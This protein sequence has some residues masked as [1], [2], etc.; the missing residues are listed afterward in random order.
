MALAIAFVAASWLTVLVLG[1]DWMPHFR[2]LLPTFPIV[3]LLAARGVASSRRP[4]AAIV[5]GALLLLTIL[6]GTIG[7][8]MFLAE[9]VTVT[10]FARLGSR[11]ATVLPPGTTIGCGSPGAIGFHSDLPVLDI[12]G[13]TDRWIARHGAVVGTQ[14]G[15][16]KTDGAYVVERKPDLLLL[17][18]IQIHRGRRER[19][20][21]PVK[22]QER[23]IIR[24]P[25]FEELYEFVNVPLGGAF[26]LSC[27]K[28]KEYFLPL[29]TRTE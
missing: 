10:A 22:I 21:L 29:E 23:E 18:N 13:L 28:L 12:L 26:Y 6:P 1:G 16:F 4:R 3:A 17:G 7:Y 24:Q 27:F 14:P 2:L 8:D 5:A 19:E 11:L 20:Q 9:R 25:G 15:H